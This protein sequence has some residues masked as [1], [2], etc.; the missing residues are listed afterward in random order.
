[1]KITTLNRYKTKLLRLKLFHKNKKLKKLNFFD[2]LLLK[3]METQLKKVL[4]ILYRLH[5][6][7]KKLLFVR[8]LLKLNPK[9]KQLI[10]NKNIVLYPNL[11]R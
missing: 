7:N 10:Q 1:M 5:I 6:A 2:Y 8:T 3:N 9:I 4:H 11:Y